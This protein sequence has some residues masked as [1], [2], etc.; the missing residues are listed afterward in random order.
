MFLKFTLELRDH[1]IRNPRAREVPSLSG[2]VI[3]VKL[4]CTKP[5]INNFAA[6]FF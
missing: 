6:E 3:M 5:K 4:E 1:E 2:A